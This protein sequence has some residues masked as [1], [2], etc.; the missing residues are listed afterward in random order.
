MILGGAVARCPFTT[1]RPDPRGS[2]LV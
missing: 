1:A 2:G